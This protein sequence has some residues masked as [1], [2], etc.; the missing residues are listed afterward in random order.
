M[1]ISLHIKIWHFNVLLCFLHKNIENNNQQCNELILWFDTWSYCFSLPLVL[2]YC[3]SGITVPRRTSHVCLYNSW[4]LGK[5]WLTSIILPPILSTLF[6]F[7]TPKKGECFSRVEICQEQW[8]CEEHL[9][10]PDFFAWLPYYV[11]GKY[12]EQSFPLKFCLPLFLLLNKFCFFVKVALI[13]FIFNCYHLFCVNFLYSKV[14][15]H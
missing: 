1:Q 2:L 13:S 7:L 6:K 4:H 8:N 10:W 3:F 12:H 11:S 9:K 14:V 15:F 5:V